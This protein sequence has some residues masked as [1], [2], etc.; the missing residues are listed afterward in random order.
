MYRMFANLGASGFGR[1]TA[2]AQH[3]LRE[4]AVLFSKVT[5][6]VA[7]TMSNPVCA[8]IKMVQIE[9][10]GHQLNN[11]LLTSTGVRRVGYVLISIL[12]TEF[13]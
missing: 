12:C 6:T 2:S 4:N 9:D 7:E 10:L 11:T 8:A 1:E 3:V 5:P 13:N